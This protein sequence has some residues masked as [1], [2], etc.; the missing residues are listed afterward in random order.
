MKRALRR[1]AA[2]G[3]M[4]AAAWAGGCDAVAW[5]LTKTIGPL[6]PEDKVQAEYSLTGKSVLVLVDVADPGLGSEYPRMETSLA[7]AIRKRLQTEE[8]A[9]P[10]VPASSLS[11]ARRSERDLPRWSVSQIGRY[12]NV[13]LVLH[14]EVYDFRLRDSPRA[15]VFHGY[16]EAAVRVVSPETEKQEWPALASAR[17]VT[18][19]TLPDVQPETAAELDTILVDG[20]GDKI[21]RI[22]FTYKPA[23]LPL[24]PKVK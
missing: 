20:L 12:F 5:L 16:T 23:D 8:A 6:V 7:E 4:T 18:A 19:E 24:R 15:N 3:L 1:W 17:L 21:A 9:G 13:D 10:V 2:L 22:F 14:V 11:A